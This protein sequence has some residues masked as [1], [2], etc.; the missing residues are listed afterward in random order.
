MAFYDDL[1]QT[2]D[3]TRRAD[4]FIA[5][6]LY[7]HARGEGGKRCLDI[8]CGSGNYTLALSNLGLNM[9]S[10]DISGSM[11]KSAQRK[12]PA[13]DWVQASAESLPFRQASFDAAFCVLSLHHIARMERMFA[14]C[15]RVL[16]ERLVIFTATREQMEYYWLN[17]YFPEAMRKS[18][19][20]MASVLEIEE[21]LLGSG[22]R[23][24]IWEP[25]D[26]KD[27]LED[28]FLYCGKD[29]P[30][31]YLDAQVR[32]GI[33]TF[34]SLAGSDEIAK[35]CQSL[36]EDIRSGRI[37]EVQQIYHGQGGD[38]TFVVASKE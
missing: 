32:A 37:K 8:A 31:Q 2:Y 25:Y 36:A 33:S 18:I 24:L 11:L 23:R 21:G 19:E 15:A 34:A 9:G 5:Q 26:V 16:T 28:L 17:D 29:R 7:F 22:F 27:D 13:I 14:E 38:Y 12:S 3:A 1:A 20:Q 10:L 35:G 4:R 30:E 6:R